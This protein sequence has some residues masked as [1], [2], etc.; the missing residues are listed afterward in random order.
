MKICLISKYPPIEGGISSNTYWLAKGLGEKGHEVHIIT[1]SL[2][3]ENEYRE[4]FDI[5]D[6][7][8]TPKNV[9]VHSTDPSPTIEA[10]PSHIPFSK[11]YC[12]KLASLAIQVIEE[13]GID[14]I[15][16]WYLLPYSVSG[17]LAK[18]FTNVPQ[19][20]RHG[21]SDLGRLYPS[22]YLNNLLVKV[23]QSAD[24]V[25]TNDKMV[26]FFENIGLHSSKIVP[27]QE[28]IVDIQAFNPEV[29]SLD[30]KNNI[31]TQKYFQDITII[32]FIGKITHHFEPKGLCEL[33]D[34]CSNIQEDFLLL[35]AANGKKLNHFKQLVKNYN[36]ENKALFLDFLPPWQIPS[37]MKACTCIVALEKN[38]SPIMGYHTSSIPA[39]ALATGRCVLLSDAL[40]KKEPYSNLKN[41]T[42]LFVVDPNNTEEIREILERLIKNP[43]IAS[44]IGN[45][46]Y[47]AIIKYENFNGFLDETIE[48]YR[49]IIA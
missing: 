19:I 9:F 39:E 10:N 35:F 30:L 42:E 11:I 20:V 37:L 49:S 17:F 40:Q 26:D 44:T 38:T 2:E 1:N 6:P 36:L 25:I 5:N 14:I 41:G 8:Y 4:K 32:G 31:T 23:I 15:D 13:H 18:S 22:P 3:V 21:G 48:L 46:G 45:N 29:I 43:E 7:N 47:K 34:V 12:E 33:L 16:S 27:M 24:A 28:M